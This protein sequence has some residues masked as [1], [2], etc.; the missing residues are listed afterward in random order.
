MKSAKHITLWTLQQDIFLSKASQ[1]GSFLSVTLQH[2]KPELC[3]FHAV[4]STFQQLQTRREDVDLMPWDVVMSAPVKC[5]YDWAVL[6]VKCSR[7]CL[8]KVVA[9][10][11][12]TFSTCK[13]HKQQSHILYD[14]MERCEMIITWTL[15]KKQT[16]LILKVLHL[17]PISKKSTS[18]VNNFLTM[19]TN[20]RDCCVIR[21]IKLRDLQDSRMNTK[22]FLG[23]QYCHGSIKNKFLETISK[24]LHSRSIMSQVITQEDFSTLLKPVFIFIILHFV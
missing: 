3:A 12:L 15:H 6:R 23:D 19:Y 10:P 16:Y 7:Y 9:C 14:T 20:K 1:S 17:Q 8:R 2:H 4:Q 21:T 5:G 22:I 18:N 11:M 13:W 24:I